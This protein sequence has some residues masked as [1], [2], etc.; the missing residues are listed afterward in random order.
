M[1]S[2]LYEIIELPD[3]EYALQRSGEEG[4]PLV[5]I[6]F[7]EEARLYLLESGMDV[8]RAMIDAGINAV[9]SL[10]TDAERELLEFDEHRVLH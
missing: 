3:G 1:A 6:G 5:T 2:A 10:G 9:E 7:S 8:A 4:E